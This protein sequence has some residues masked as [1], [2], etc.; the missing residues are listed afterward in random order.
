MTQRIQPL[1]TT[2]RRSLARKP[3]PMQMRV[4]RFE[5]QPF[6]VKAPKR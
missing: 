6:I 2:F 3:T 4:Q 5:D 1:K